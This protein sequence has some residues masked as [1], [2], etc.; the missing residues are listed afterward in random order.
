MTNPRQSPTPTT[1][2]HMRQRFGKPYRWYVLVTVM[3]G[4]MASIISSTIVNV[5]IPDLTRHFTV[6]QERAQW[7]SAG[8]MIAMTL[9][10][11]ATPWLLGRFGLRRT[12]AGACLLLMAGGIG[13][14][15]SNDFTL[16]IAM[17]VA[18]GIAAGILQPIPN[19][20][21]MRA[22]AVH[23]R[24][25]A[26]GIFG[27][28]VVLAPAIGPSVGGF[29]VEQF[30][31]RS[32]FF[33]VVPLCL[34]ALALAKVFLP[35]VSSFIEPK[36]PLDWKGL[37]WISAGTL[38]LLNGMVQLHAAP[39]WVALAM[40]AAGFAGIGSFVFYQ[41]RK[42]DPLLHVR[43]FQHRQ[44]SMGALVAFVYGFAI[45]GST[46]LLPV[47]LQMAL[48]Y[49]PSA[50]G[51]VLLPA[52]LVLAVT[53]LV[54]GRMS[55]SFSASRMVTIGAMLMAI[56]LAL[57]AEVGAL[58]PYFL[59]VGF[60]IVGRV[61]LGLIMPALSLGSVAELQQHEMPQAV[62]MVSF[63]CQL[64]GA[65]GVSMVGIVLE[66]RLAATGANAAGE[67]GTLLPAFGQTFLFL[68]AVSCCA[69]FAAWFMKPRRRQLAA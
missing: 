24:G 50:A 36:R 1:I 61:G 45:F 16:L 34:V 35:A 39:L 66:W 64:G 44:L 5:A 7:I 22:F 57:M 14:G 60:V 37:L 28:G 53:M 40:I 6:G 26:I 48:H 13:G 3:V 51:L 63:M 25:R 42:R 4:M 29:L 65:M 69:A 58:T 11:T 27:L 41:L 8:F 59:L 47:F 49:T 21:I 17:R 55:D 30:G 56:S 31:W 68:A 9:A 32:I 54:A 10:L 20:V 46:Y 2:D 15:F 43:L 67:A 33:V 23:E 52:G 12:Y 19:V 38:L 18:E 62:S